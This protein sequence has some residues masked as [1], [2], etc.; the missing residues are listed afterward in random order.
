MAI[1]AYCGIVLFLGYNYCYNER[2]KEA[3]NWIGLHSGEINNLYMYKMQKIVPY[4]S[5]NSSRS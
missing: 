1:I 5:R 2:W 4:V 3:Q